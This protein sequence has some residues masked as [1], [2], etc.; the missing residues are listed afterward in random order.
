MNR[1]TCEICP[2]G[3]YY[4]TEAM[5]LQPADTDTDD[6]T[7]ATEETFL[8]KKIFRV[9]TV[10]TKIPEFSRPSSMKFLE[11]FHEVSLC[12]QLYHVNVCINTYVLTNALYRILHHR[13]HQLHTIKQMALHLMCWLL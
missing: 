4:T 12:V 10:L 2:N 7:N 1:L 11:F 3:Y 6:G 5:A 13:L 8:N 9:S